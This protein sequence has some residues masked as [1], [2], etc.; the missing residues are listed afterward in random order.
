MLLFKFPNQER[1]ISTETLPAKVDEGTENVVYVTWEDT[2]DSTHI[3]KVSTTNSVT[4]VEYAFGTWGN[5]ASLTYKS[6][7]K[8]KGG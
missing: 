7:E 4:S 5:R 3:Q 8:Y 6:I 1:Y 2:E